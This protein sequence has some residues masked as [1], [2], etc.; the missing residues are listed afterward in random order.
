MS[1]ALLTDLYQLTMAQGYFRQSM[2]ERR[3]VFHLTFRNCPFGGNFVLACGLGPALEHFQSLRFINEDL[4]YLA[5]LRGNDG[6]ALFGQDF[7]TYLGEMRPACDVA[8][9][10][11]GSAV[12]PHE[13]LLRLTG[14]IAQCQILETPLLTLLNFQSLVATKAA[15]LCRAAAGRPVID[16]GLRRAQGMDGGLGA[17]RAAYVGGVAATSNV[18]AGLR[19]GIPV[20]GTHAHSWIMAFDDEEEAFVAYAE[21]MPNNCIFLV[22]TYDTLDGVE[23]AVRVAVGLRRRGHEMVGLRL[24]S[25]ELG[26]LS[27]EVRRRLDAA[28][29]PAAKIVASNDLDEYRIAELVASGAQIDLWGVGTRLITAFEQPTLGGVFKLAALEGKDGTLVPRLK[30]SEQEVKVSN[31]CP[32]QVRRYEQEGMF[33][34]DVIYDSSRSLPDPCEVRGIG[35]GSPGQSWKIETGTVGEDL[36]RPMAV[37]GRPLAEPES[38]EQIRRRAQEQ[39]AKLPSGVLDLQSPAPYPVGLE[40]GLE[41][42]KAALIRALRRPKEG[43]TE[44]R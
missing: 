21:A 19:Y 32:Q 43:S 15:R 5:G 22:D 10:P 14:P 38:L 23:K 9:V 30:L 26:P 27:Q 6:K 44:S 40:A 29:F 4:E 2:A 7:L 28:G 39:L 25:G 1:S 24:D 34:G 41:E 13:P 42:T 17:T 11:E 35:P 20:K 12:F 3:A 31:P 33:I 18:L 16:F 36:L 37:E 8:A